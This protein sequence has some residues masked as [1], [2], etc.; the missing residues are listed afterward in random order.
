MVRSLGKH[1]FEWTG[2]RVAA[3]SSRRRASL[4]EISKRL[5]LTYEQVLYQ[6]NQSLTELQTLGLVSQINPGDEYEF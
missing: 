1:I 5:S 3:S 4:T 2:K 6:Y